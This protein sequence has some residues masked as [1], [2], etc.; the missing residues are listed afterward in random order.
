M[1]EHTEQ[2]NLKP[3]RPGDN[4]S[5]ESILHEWV[6]YPLLRAQLAQTPEG[7]VIMPRQREHVL[8]SRYTQ[9]QLQLECT[10]LHSVPVARLDDILP[11]FRTESGRPPDEEV[12]PLYVA[13]SQDR[14][15]GD[16]QWKISIN[17]ETIHI[18]LSAG[19]IKGE[20]GQIIGA[21]ASWHD[22]TELRNTK[23]RLERLRENLEEE[24]LKRTRELRQAKEAAEAA[25]RVKTRFLDNVSHELKTPLTEILGTVGML[26]HPSSEI[27]MPGWIRDG[28][29]TVRNS[30][31]S[32]TGLVDGLIDLSRLDLDDIELTP[33]RTDFIWLLGRVV[34]QHETRA[35]Q[36]NLSFVTSVDRD[37]PGTILCDPGRLSQILGALLSN[38]I[39]F[40]EQGQVALAVER[41]EESEESVTLCFTVSDTGIGIPLEKEGTVFDH[42]TQLEDSFDKNYEGL[43]IGLTIALHLAK[44]MGGE[45]RIHQNQPSG[46][47]FTFCAAFQKDRE[48]EPAAFSPSQTLEDLPRLKILLVE[49]N[50]IN[51]M[52]MHKALERAGHQV[53]PAGNGREALEKLDR[54]TDAVLMDIQM[55]EMDGLEAMQRIREEKN[56]RFDPRVPIIALTAY[57]GSGDRQRFL[58][59]GMDGYVA[60]PVDFNELARVLS[61][62]VRRRSLSQD[63]QLV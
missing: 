4:I 43:G 22:I 29:N 19:P 32:M 30:A 35:R 40:S 61:K 45:I 52:F 49:D 20:D 7:F 38:A 2:E 28:L 62:V 54:H 8:L 24:V 23:E 14:T 6:K 42:F 57:A 41:K 13:V 11:L 17:D 33:R 1:P 25:S 55:P 10:T 58:S 39:K 27:D 26:L 63:T 18:L 46:T 59:Q 60:K 21:I 51:R 31:A 50:M 36:K 5:G 56:I 44:K 53:V 16:A 9:E 3:D 12:F 47:R 37:I 15:I 48:T 34:N